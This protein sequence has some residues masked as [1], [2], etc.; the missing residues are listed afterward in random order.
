MFTK[1]HFSGSDILV[2][3]NIIDEKSNGQFKCMLRIV[4]RQENSDIYESKRKKLN[5]IFPYESC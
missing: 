2:L 1:V 4:V 5:K 3:N